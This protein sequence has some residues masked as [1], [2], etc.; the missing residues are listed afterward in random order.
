MNARSVIFVSGMGLL[1]ALALAGSIFVS[2]ALFGPQGIIKAG[3]AFEA[4][5][6]ILFFRDPLP[7]RRALGTWNRPYDKIRRKNTDKDRRP[8]L[9]WCR[10]IEH[11]HPGH[12]RDV[13]YVFA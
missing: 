9:G 4:V 5:G 11:H 2:F 8:H 7:R 6:G 1:T 3:L 12:D 10:I 13:Q